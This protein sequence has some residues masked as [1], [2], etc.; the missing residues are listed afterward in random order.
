M[1]HWGVEWP[2][3]FFS[4]VYVCEV[5]SIQLQGPTVGADTQPPEDMMVRRWQRCEHPYVEHEG[6]TPSHNFPAV[7]L[8]HDERIMQWNTH[9]VIILVN[10]LFDADLKTHRARPALDNSSVNVT[11]IPTVL[12]LHHRVHRY[13]FVNR[14][15][16]FIIF[17][18]MRQSHND[19]VL[20]KVSTRTNK[21][22]VEEQS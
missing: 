19:T 7:C 13:E 8:L 21:T 16:L 5:P 22:V 9:V 1:T 10:Y 17:K 15:M 18:S 6:S 3:F 14:F 4:C 12:H 2:S 20:K 11:S